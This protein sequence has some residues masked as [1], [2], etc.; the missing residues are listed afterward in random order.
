M[1]RNAG[2]AGSAR[3]GRQTGQLK[4]NTEC[5][6]QPGNRVHPAKRTN[7]LATCKG[8]VTGDFPDRLQIA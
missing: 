2:T 6:L 7:T 1:A 4:A 5:P 8:R 3:E